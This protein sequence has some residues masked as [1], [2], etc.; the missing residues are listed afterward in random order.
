MSNLRQNATRLVEI[1]NEDGIGEIPPAVSRWWTEHAYP[2]LRDKLHYEY[3][4]LKSD[5]NYVVREFDGYQMY[6]SLGDPGLSKQ[7]ILDGSREETAMALFKSE[8]KEGM[9]V[10]D[11]GANLGYYALMEAATVGSSG[12]VY[13]FEPVPR[14][15]EILR[16]STELNGFD[17]LEVFETAVSDS[18]GVATMS[19]TNESNWGSL[20][21]DEPKRKLSD[22]YRNRRE[23][24]TVGTQD[25]STIRL[26]DFLPERGVTDIDAVRMDVEGHEI[27]VLDGMAELL[28]KASSPCKVMVEF[29]NIIFDDAKA[30]IGNS[31]Q[32][33]LDLG[34]EPMALIDGGEHVP[35]DREEFVETLCS[36]DSCPHVLIKK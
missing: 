24:I 25:V 5:S 22:Y 28:Q 30:T 27:E 14:N 31:V 10:V 12:A 29:H 3:V 17:N 8:L 13:A 21:D 33:L 2:E 11:V 34:F 18:S 32:D 19:I 6:L 1:A 15:V 36:Y 26:D 20:T 4:K 9:T 16:G 35:F 23:K 7:L